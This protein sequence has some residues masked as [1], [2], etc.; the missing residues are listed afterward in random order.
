[1]EGIMKNLNF[2][3]LKKI[4]GQ[5][6]HSVS[7]L[8]E[9]NIVQGALGP[10]GEHEFKVDPKGAHGILGFREDAKAKLMFY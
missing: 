6:H 8:K 10:V 2:S 4:N 5:A 7:I 9:N 1:M 3:A